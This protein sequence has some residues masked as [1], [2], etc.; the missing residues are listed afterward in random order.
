MNGWTRQKYVYVPG[1]R[2]FG[3]FH[4]SRFAAA[5]AKRGPKPSSP[6]SKST[7]PLA[8][9]YAMPVVRCYRAPCTR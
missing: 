6:E 5:V 4:V 1:L 2:F 9:G 3:V 7:R 8:S